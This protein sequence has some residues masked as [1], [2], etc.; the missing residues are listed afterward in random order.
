MSLGLL[1]LWA[2]ALVLALT[3]LG[4]LP[5]R[6]WDEAIAARVALELSRADGLAQWLPTIWGDPYLNKPPGLHLLIAGTI[7]L[8]R[9]LS[10]HGPDALPPEGLIRLAPALL[11]T[12]VVPLGGWIAREL[13]PKDHLAPLATAA[14]LLTTLPLARHGRMAM[15]DGA[16][17]SA[18]ALLWLGLLRASL[19][20]WR[21]GA[22][23]LMAGLAGS[24]LLLLKAPILLPALA[25][26]LLA[27]R[28]DPERRPRRW[29]PMLVLLMAGL[30]P[31][32]AWHG[33]HA[34]SRGGDALHLWIGD[35]AARVLLSEGEGSQLGWRVPLL[36]LCKGGWPW[37]PLW[38]FGLAVAW[39][40]RRLRRGRWPL[41][42]QGGM[43]L[44]ILPLRTQLPWYSHP[45][46]LP[47]ALICAPALVH[48][49][50]RPSAGQGPSHRHG[51]LERVPLIWVGLGG[52]LL[53]FSLLLAH[54][55][56]GNLSRDLHTARPLL[57]SAG[58]GWLL[59][60]I[61][62]MQAH[63]RQ[64]LLGGA[65]LSL[66]TAATLLL[67]MLSPHWNWELAEQWPVQPVAAM[68]RRHNAAPVRLW[69]QAA[70]PS[71]SWYA[72][73]PIRKWRA[74]RRERGGPGWVLSRPSDRP[75]LPATCS[76][77]DSAAGWL[78]LQC[79]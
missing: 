70:R 12:L 35:G 30:L 37:L 49:M 45:L 59:G 21:S 2:L 32:L 40:E 5:L 46:W 6:D 43:A 68:V 27:L 71:L 53:C 69:K 77:I 10:G 36:E 23:S 38:P 47:F 33:L 16:Q 9:W 19:P 13:R 50:R 74:T 18:M 26:G 8:W 56:I 7:R 15:L 55:A 60:G 14:I 1:A 73:Q 48:L 66:G 44:A 61:L 78:L 41:L 67:L 34:W 28:L 58:S 75:A 72:E 76:D 57:F 52:A 22:A 64:R 62:L 65:A 31:G 3:G 39:R 24:G 63:Q 29:A 54:P 42:L 79:R 4:S 51:L 25:T 20:T 11:S 17:L